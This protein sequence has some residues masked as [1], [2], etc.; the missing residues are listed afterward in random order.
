MA[1]VIPFQSVRPA[2]DKVHLVTSRSFITYSQQE[3]IQKLQS[4]P[5]TFLHIIYPDAF[6]KRKLK[7][8]EKLNAIKEKYNQFLQHHIL[9]I[10]PTPSFYIYQ[11]QTETNLFLGIIGCSSIDDYLNNIIKKHEHTL[12]EKEKKL[13]DYLEVV[14]IHAEPVLMFH[15]NDTT[16]DALLQ[17]IISA[18]IPLYDFTTTDKVRHTI[19]KT[20]TEENNRIT[21]I[22]TGIDSL[23]IADGHHRSAASALYG[24]EKRK[25]NP[26]YNGTEPFNFFLCYY[27]QEKYLKVWEFNRIV[28]LPHRS[29][30]DTLLTQLAQYFLLQPVT[31][32]KP[33]PDRFY[34]FLLYFQDK[35][36]RA[37]L[38]ETF[39]SHLQNEYEKIPACIV[40]K[41]FFEPILRINDLRNTPYVEFVPGKYGESALLQQLHSKHYDLAVMLFPASVEQIKNTAINGQVM[42]PKSTWIEPKLRSGLT[43]FQLH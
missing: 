17:E 28:K 42:P 36:Y 35:W 24:L 27:I 11:Q 25:Q 10:D 30:S 15:K 29:L 14:D 5:Y 22:Y 2:K 43:M 40:D 8:T 4:N 16:L 7:G 34:S 9:I 19:W 37:T 41:Y 1:I 31:H 13:K 33:L 20:N 26:H 18:K 32:T 39:L 3:L 21:E 23:F 12:I 38:K 6:T